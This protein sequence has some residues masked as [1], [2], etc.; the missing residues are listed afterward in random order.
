MTHSVTYLLSTFNKLEYLR[1]ALKFLLSNV[2]PFDNICVVDGGSTDGTPEYLEHLKKEGLISQYISEPDH[3]EA[4]GINKGLLMAKTDFIK[5]VSDDD[6]FDFKSIKQCI[7]FLGNNPD[8]DVMASNGL[9]SSIDNPT[10][11]TVADYRSQ[12]NLYCSGSVPFAFCGLGL[13]I[14]KSSLPV[15]GLFNTS[16]I[17]VDAEYSLRV[18]NS[19]ANLAWCMQP[20]WVRILNT[21]SNSS[22]F[23]SKCAEEGDLLDTVYFNKITLHRPLMRRLR[24]LLKKL[25]AKDNAVSFPCVSKEEIYYRYYSILRAMNSDVELDFVSR[26][27]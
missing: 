19:Q 16:F 14:R 9:Y 10:F 22:R 20:L 24:F 3:G 13:L 23:I 18:S 12:Y 11:Y 1:V 6:V 26:Q 7:A 25:V 17:R 21:S 15:L 27:K 4:H 5:I 2:E 8:I